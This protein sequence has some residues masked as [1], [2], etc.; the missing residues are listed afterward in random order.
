MT[1]STRLTRR[2][3]LSAFALAPLAACAETDV[4]ASLG[5]EPKLPRRTFRALRVDVGPM[6]RAGVP[7]WARRVG[8]AVEAAARPAFADL[9]DPRDRRAPVL[10]LEIDACDFP[11]YVGGRWRQGPLGSFGDDAA[12]DWI[13][14][15]VVYGAVRRRVNVHRAS[16]DAGPWYAPEV[17]Q[18]RLENV[19]AVFA[20][21]ARKEFED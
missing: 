4:R 8:L 17:D 2:T 16:A 15:H 10:T 9:I 18:R 1:S 20:A 11:I 7:G 5:L 21:W 13:E 3:L 6:V 12:T 14:G 19:A